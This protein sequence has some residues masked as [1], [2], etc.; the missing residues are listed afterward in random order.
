MGTHLDRVIWLHGAKGVDQYNTVRFIA[1]SKLPHLLTIVGD[2]CLRLI[3]QQYSR[4]R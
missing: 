2:L 3:L 4:L 1:P